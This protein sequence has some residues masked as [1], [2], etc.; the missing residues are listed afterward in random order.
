VTGL[1]LALAVAAGPVR[2]PGAPPASAQV[3][4]AVAGLAFDQHLNA[5]LPLDAAFV[6]E[7]GATVRLGELFR[8]RPVILVLAYYRCPQLC[9]LVLNGLLEALRGIPYRPGEEYTV[10][11]ISFDPRET[12]AIADAKKSTY[13]AAFDQPPGIPGPAVDDWHFLTGQKDQIDRVADTVG[14][15]YAFDE[16]NDRFNHPSGIVLVTPEGKVSRYLFGIRYSPRDLKLGLVEASAGQVGSVV[17]QLLL[18]CFHYD[19][20]QGRYAFAVMNAVRV[21]GGVTVLALSL[22]L[23]RLLRR[24]RMGRLPNPARRS[25]ATT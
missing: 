22:W 6:N 11:T 9:N 23:F 2:E 15:R 8:G 16:K 3:P 1:L 24:E 7:R 5:Q 17:D 19:Q 21:G 4:A 12:P 13:L 25:E 20:S 14:F 18:F 10:I